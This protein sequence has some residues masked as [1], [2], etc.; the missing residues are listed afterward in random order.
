MA[1]FDFSRAGSRQQ[2][3]T[4]IDPEEIFRAC[5]ISDQNINDLW[6]GQGDALRQWHNVRHLE[7]VGVVLN[8]G[9]GKTLVGLL[10]AQSLVNETQRQ[11]VYSCSSIQ[12]VEQTAEKARGYGIDVATYHGREFT[13]EDAYYRAIFPCVTTYQALFNGKTRFRRDELAAVIFD[14][15]HTAENILR[16]QFSLRI[17]RRLFPD[18]YNELVALFSEY[19]RSVGRAS[20]YGEVDKGTSSRLFFIPPFEVRR[21]AQE[22]RRILSE[23]SLSEHRDTMFAW[24]H[25]IDHE[26][27]CC[28]LV[29]SHEITA[30]PPTVPVSTL[31]YFGKGTRR[32][33]LSATL[34]APD[35]FARA[36]GRVPQELVAPPTP[37]GECER[38]ILIPSLASEVEAKEDIRAAM[39]VIRDKKAFILVPTYARGEDWEDITSPP[40]PEKVTEDL[41]AFRNADAP[42]KLLLT[43]RYDGID[44]PGN[45]CRV[46]VID[47]LPAGS[48]PLERFQ[49]DS[50]N[51]DNSTRSTIASR[52]VQS[53]GRISRGMSDHGVVLLTGE[54]L[55]KWIRIPRN[56]ALLPEFL[57]HQIRLGEDISRSATTAERLS[58]AVDGFLNRHPGWTSRYSDHM[59]TP[60]PVPPAIDSDRARDIALAEAQFGEFLWSRDFHRAASVLEKIQNQAVQFSQFT[61]AWLTM[62]WAYAIEMAGDSEA[63]NDL[64]RRAHALSPNI[65]R[66]APQQELVTVPV[67][68]QIVNIAQQ[69]QMGASQGMKVAAPK[70]LQQDLVHLNGTG[71]VRQIE[72]ALRCLGQYLGLESMRPDK[73]YDTGPDVLWLGDDG[74]ALV[75][76]V[77]TD[78]AEESSY[79]KDDLGQ[80]RDHVQWVLDR[81]EVTRIEQVFVGPFLP[82][83]DRANPSPDMVVIG[84][85]QFDNIGKKL[86]STLVDVAENALP[87]KLI[88][89]LNQQMNARGLVWP[90]VVDSLEKETLVDT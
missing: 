9:A 2:A 19:H 25:I 89:E 88:D 1:E 66:L 4:L 34:A 87:L 77:K 26:E 78:K 13:N 58:A 18:A 6:L 79:R 83:S 40:P 36:F 75:M 41:V 17:Q 20:S 12:L 82:S 44:L 65:P 80:L 5:S 90:T 60:P 52:I 22:V 37:A 46:M 51:M 86:I 29:S 14:D 73:E 49:R 42:E 71:S 43:A 59:R 55:T 68:Q 39:D 54:E 27:L 45:T 48:G 3:P 33:Y 57:Q 30:T 70:R 61:G 81:F 56:R 64:Y 11:V 10:I 32:V 63:A 62:W 72:E 76:E 24:D 7:D 74:F 84:L 35:A 47:D 23:A 69:M 53:F 50:L 38:M 21:H 31:P 28:W 85:D 8:T 15:A 67:P 16:D